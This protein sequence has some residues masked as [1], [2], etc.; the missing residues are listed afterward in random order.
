MTNKNYKIIQDVYGV[1]EQG[2]YLVI[3]MNK[4]TL[5]NLFQFKKEALQYLKEIKTNL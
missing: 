2:F 5:L 1:Y 4:N 3:D